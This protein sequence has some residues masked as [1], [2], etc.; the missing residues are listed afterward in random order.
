MIFLWFSADELRYGLRRF[1][2]DSLEGMEHFPVLKPGEEFTG[3]QEVIG[4]FWLAELGLINSKRLIHKDSAFLKR[5][6]YARNQ[7][8]VEITEDKDCAEHLIFKRVYTFLLKINKSDLHWN[9]Q[10]TC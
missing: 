3:I 9:F 5:L 8:A 10:G 1:T 4:I 7:R 6:L 2:D